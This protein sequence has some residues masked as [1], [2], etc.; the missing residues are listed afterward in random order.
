MDQTTEQKFEGGRRRYEADHRIAQ[1]LI[2]VMA[3]LCVAGFM[4]VS[5]GV[6]AG[7]YLAILGGLGTLA[8]I[9]QIIPGRCCLEIDP[10]KLTICTQFKQRH[11]YWTDVRELG[12]HDMGLFQVVGLRLIPSTLPKY[13]LKRPAPKGEWDILINNRYDLPN[14]E[15]VKQLNLVRNSFSPQ[16]PPVA[17][18]IPDDDEDDE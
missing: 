3:L 11:Y 7:W 15:L 13:G 16:P 18:P 1:L 2:P 8:L 10:E 17:R 5:N 4:V 6:M 12:T 9:V 14:R